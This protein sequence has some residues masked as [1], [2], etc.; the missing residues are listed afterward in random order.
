MTWCDLRSGASLRLG[1]VPQYRSPWKEPGLYVGAFFAGRSG[2][3]FLG[4]GAGHNKH[5]RMEERFSA[6]VGAADTVPL[7]DRLDWCL[8]TRPQGGLLLDVWWARPSVYRGI[9]VPLQ[10][11]EMRARAKGAPVPPDDLT[12]A[13][14]LFF[15][16][17]ELVG[18]E[19]GILVDRLAPSF[20]FMKELLEELGRD[21]IHGQTGLDDER[22]SGLSV[23]DS[24]R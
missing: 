22:R 15:P 20:V 7:P 14:L 6:Y 21:R 5:R 2:G 12:V 10:F 24:I 19:L 13:V 17:G 1:L 4:I 18:L 3:A 23:G 11:E 8:L 9:D 16:N